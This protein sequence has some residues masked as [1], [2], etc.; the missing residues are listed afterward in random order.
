MFSESELLH[1]LL[2]S[3]GRTPHIRFLPEEKECFEFWTWYVEHKVKGKIKGIATH[4]AHQVAN[5][6]SPLFGQ[7][8][9]CMGKV[10]GMP[11]YIFMKRDKSLGLEFKVGKNKLSLSQGAVQMW[12]DQEGIPY[13]EVRSKEEAIEYLYREGFMND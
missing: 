13:Y 8:L 2:P 12:F 9:A 10:K 6:K 7:K 1:I 3:F 11:D 4:I 5:N